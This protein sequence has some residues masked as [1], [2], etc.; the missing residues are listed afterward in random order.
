MARSAFPDRDP[1]LQDYPEP[2]GPAAVEPRYPDYGRPERGRASEAAEKVG[3]LVGAAVDQVRHLPDRLQEMKRRFTVISGRAQKDAKA[4]AGE[5]KDEAR[6]KVEEARTRAERLAHDYP[7]QLIAGAAA[8]G[9]VVGILLRVW[10]DHA[11]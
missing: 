6:L 2:V 4:K 11:D 3:N 10:R 8:T 9:L 5:L 7:L 1:R